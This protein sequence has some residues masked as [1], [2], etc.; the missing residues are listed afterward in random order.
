MRD[1]LSSP[2]SLDLLVHILRTLVLLVYGFTMFSVLPG[3]AIV[4]PEDAYLFTDGRYFLQ[5][6][7][8][9]DKYVLYF[10]VGHDELNNLCVAT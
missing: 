2:A 5:A 3:C 6:S 10:N 8:Q 4:T 7:K 1:A 9:L